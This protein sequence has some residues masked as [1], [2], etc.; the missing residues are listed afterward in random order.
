[1]LREPQFGD[2]KLEWRLDADVSHSSDIQSG[3]V[4]D[5]YC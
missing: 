4:F 1:M 5:R 2:Q 3:C